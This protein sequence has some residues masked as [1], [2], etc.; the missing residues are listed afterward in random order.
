LSNHQ[1]IP[2]KSAD[3]TITVNSRGRISFFW[4]IKSGSGFGLL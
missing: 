3:V 4:D 1:A 2:P